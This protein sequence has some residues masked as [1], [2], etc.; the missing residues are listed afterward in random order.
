[1][2]YITKTVWVLSMVSLF[3]DMASEM[4]YPVMPIYLESIGFSILFIGFLEGMAEATAGLSKGYF[5]K[6]SDQMGIRAPFVRW[7]YA[8]SAIS[9]PIIAFFTFPLW[10]LFA[11]TMDRLG[12]GLRTGARDAILSDEATPATK[13]KIFGFHRSMDT[14]GAVLGPMLALTYLYF[15]PKHYT[16]LFF[17]A[18]APGLIAIAFSFL[19]TNK[20]K[21]EPATAAFK[22]VSFFA[23]LNYWKDCHPEYRKL[24]SGLLLFTLINSSDI[25]LL[26]K[27]KEAGLNDTSIIFIYIFYNL[28]YAVFSFP[29]GILADNIGMKKVF[30]S[31][32]VFFTIVYIGMGLNKNLMIYYLLFFLYGLYAASTEGIAKAWITNI[33][34]QKDTATAIGTYTAFQSILTLLASSLAGA[35][36]FTFGAEATFLVSGFVTIV[37]IIYLARFPFKK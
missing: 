18:F 25:F 5:G 31:G 30:L 17:I 8:L 26:L 3:T 29:I 9:K 24:V 33:S 28:V 12:K 35:I 16:T 13:G 22:P 7:G 37:I 10:I 4:L 34:E 14:L 27:M 11:R 19:L 32:L 36:W 15:Y 2:K 21:R 6:Y 23:F 1:M 20:K